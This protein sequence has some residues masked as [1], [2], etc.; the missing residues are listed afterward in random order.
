M[1]FQQRIGTV[2]TAEWTSPFGLDRDDVGFPLVPCED[3]VIVESG[4]LAAGRAASDAGR[5]S[6]A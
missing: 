2:G 5:W 1:P 4:G 6:S 3:L